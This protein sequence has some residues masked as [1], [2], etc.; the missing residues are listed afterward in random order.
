MSS[1]KLQDQPIQQF[2]TVQ[3]T[4]ELTFLCDQNAIQIFHNDTLKNTL[5]LTEYSISF[6]FKFAYDFCRSIVTFNLS[7]II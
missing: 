2:H 7:Q 4:L 1:N 5:S 6:R 3:Y